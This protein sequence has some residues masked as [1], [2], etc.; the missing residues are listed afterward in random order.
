MDVCYYCN[1]VK[2]LEYQK[3]CDLCYDKMI[4]KIVAIKKYGLKK[5]QLNDLFS[6]KSDCCKST[7]CDKYSENDLYVLQDKLIR[8]MSKN[9]KQYKILIEC[10]KNIDELKKSEENY[11]KKKLDVENLLVDLFKKYDDKYI[12]LCDD[13]IKY[14]ISQYCKSESS[15]T[16]IAF[17]I[18]S[19]IEAEFLNDKKLKK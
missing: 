16:S 14:L 5:I 15:C 1:D 9:D 17:K 12:N 19:I 18:C 13:T 6:V 11:L 10:K 2:H 7:L 3:V 8:T 4:Y